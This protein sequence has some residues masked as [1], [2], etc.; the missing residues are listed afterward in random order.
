MQYRSILTSNASLKSLLLPPTLH[1]ATRFTSNTECEER[2]LTCE[3]LMPMLSALKFT[4]NESMPWTNVERN[5]LVIQWMINFQFP[6]QRGGHHIIYLDS[7]DANL[8]RA[9]NCI[10]AHCL[11]YCPCNA[12]AHDAISVRKG[13]TVSYN[14]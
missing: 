10:Q 4:S 12:H 9:R 8:R 13:I 14:V 7:A 1:R 5:I 6:F 3:G 11:F 2:N